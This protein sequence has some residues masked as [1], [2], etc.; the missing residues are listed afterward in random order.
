MHHKA[1][2][3][4]QW[5]G[6]CT[7]NRPHIV[8]RRRMNRVELGS[9]RSRAGCRPNVRSASGGCCHC[10]IALANCPNIAGCGDGV[11]PVVK[12]AQVRALHHLEGSRAARGGGRSGGSGCRWIWPRGG[13]VS[14]SGSTA[15]ST[16]RRADTADSRSEKNRIL[17]K[18]VLDIRMIQVYNNFKVL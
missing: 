1:G 10:A 11:E 13:G 7:S 5:M 15:W 8:S 14:G 18:L 4:S 17:R 3:T 6:W 12:I 9:A 16:R 2:P